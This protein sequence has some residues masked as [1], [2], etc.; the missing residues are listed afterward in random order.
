M[1]ETH[2]EKEN[3]RKNKSVIQVD[4]KEKA[5]IVIRRVKENIESKKTKNHK[6][7][8]ESTLVNKD[9]EVDKNCTRINKN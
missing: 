7:N 5:K 2:Q 6:K 1:I 4:I 3:K 8:K 9:Q